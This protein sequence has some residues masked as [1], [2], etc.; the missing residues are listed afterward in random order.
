MTASIRNTSEH[1]RDERAISSL[2]DRTAAPRGD[3]R[4]LF[5]GEFHRLGFRATVRSYLRVLAAANVYSILRRREQPQSSS[6][7]N[8]W[9]DDGGSVRVERTP[10]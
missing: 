3:V 10:A 2:C 6:K 5:A 1:D 7:L 4:A 8:R 9:E